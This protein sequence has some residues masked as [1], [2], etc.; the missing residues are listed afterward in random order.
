MH[1]RL[2]RVF[3]AMGQTLLP[4]HLR[5]QEDSVL[6]DSA[7]RFSLQEAPSFGL[8]RLQWNEALLGEG[9]LSL[10][11]MT[12]VTPFGLLLKLKENAQVAPL[13]LNLSGGTLLPVYL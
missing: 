3:W 7:L 1:N 10:E 13:N 4:A 6:A 8:Y 2:P 12:L 5:T 11:E 9:V